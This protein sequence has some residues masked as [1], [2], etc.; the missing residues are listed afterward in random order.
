MNL[1]Q[2]AKYKAEYAALRRGRHREEGVREE[3]LQYAYGRSLGLFLAALVV[4]LT[5][6]KEPGDNA[7]GLH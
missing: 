4:E 7:Q 3:K 2:R 1:P 6:Q 5:E